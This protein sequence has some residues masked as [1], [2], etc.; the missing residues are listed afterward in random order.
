MGAKETL[1][2]APTVLPKGFSCLQA[3]PSNSQDSLSLL[4]PFQANEVFVSQQTRDLSDFADFCPNRPTQSGLRRNS[5][6]SNVRGP[7]PA[8]HIEFYLTLCYWIT[9]HA[10]PWLT[11]ISTLGMG[12]AGVAASEVTTKPAI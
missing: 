2:K 9:A 4:S 10:L 3:Y 8:R 6:G 1:T 7:G 11:C 5:S 12:T